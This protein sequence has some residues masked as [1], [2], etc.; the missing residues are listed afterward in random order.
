MTTTPQNRAQLDGFWWFVGVFLVISVVMNGAVMYYG[1]D[2]ASPN[3]FEEANDD[4]VTN[5]ETGAGCGMV[6]LLKALIGVFGVVFLGGLANS[7]LRDTGTSE[8]EQQ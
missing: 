7:W 3:E 4:I 2:V 5:C 6:P 1:V 8:N